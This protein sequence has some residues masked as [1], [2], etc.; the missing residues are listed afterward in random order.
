MLASAA[1]Q[2]YLAGRRAGL[3]RSDDSAVIEVFRGAVTAV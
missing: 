2:V 1:A 3:G